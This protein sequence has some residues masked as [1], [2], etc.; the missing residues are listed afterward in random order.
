MKIGVISDTHIPVS[1]AKL[2][3]KLISALQDCDLILHAGDFVDLKTLELLKSITNVEA[4]CG[5]MDPP[6]LRNVLENKKVVSI[7]G[8]I[9]CIMHGYGDPRNLIEIL[10]TTFSKEHPDIIVFGHSHKPMSEYIDNILFFNPG[11]PTDK[12]FAPYRS[13]GIIEI[14]DRD[15][16]ATIHRL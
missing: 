9:I 7:A 2:P 11:S 6:E 5:N 1:A 13:Y 14:K 16:K 8:K 4:V 15:I 12:V 10:K 3:D